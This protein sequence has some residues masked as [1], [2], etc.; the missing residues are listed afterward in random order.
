[1][2]HH[3]ELHQP[4]KSFDC[5]DLLEMIVNLELEI[6]PKFKNVLH[7]YFFLCPCVLVSIW[8]ELMKFEL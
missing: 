6:L 4:S 1:M 8:A 7:T 5:S 3:Q 2:D